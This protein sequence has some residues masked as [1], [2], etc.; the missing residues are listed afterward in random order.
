MKK[1]AE[2][3]AFEAE[4]SLEGHRGSVASVKF[5]RDGRLLASASADKTVKLWALDGQFQTELLGHTGGVSD[6]SWVGSSLLA[7]A[8]DD[9]TVMI[10]DIETQKAISTLTGHSNYVFCVSFNPTGNVLASGSFDESVRLWDVRTG[11]CNVVLP[12]H[13]DPVCSVD[14]NKDG[15]VLASSSYDGLLRLW[16][17][18]SGSCLKTL[19]SDNVSLSFC[20]WAPNGKLL[21][22]STLDSTLKLWDQNG[23]AVKT[24]TGHTNTRY[25]VFSC[26]GIDQVRGRQYVVSGS[27][28]CKA[29]IWDLQQKSV[30]QVLEGHSAPVIGIDYHSNQNII[31]TCSMADDNTVKLWHAKELRSKE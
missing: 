3:P 31:A 2:A 11:K 23:R 4:L 27:E 22:A 6:V 9:R 17:A 21:L 24:Y 13:S 28:D 20:R 5:A 29:Y 10:W 7:T 14:W 12:A 30:V 16:D 26:F 18:G 1:P 19:I 8:S 15:S 25:S